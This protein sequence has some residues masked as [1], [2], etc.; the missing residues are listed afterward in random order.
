V[1]RSGVDL[2]VHRMR[3]AE[4]RDAHAAVA[5]DE[6]VRRL[7][8][9]VD[10][11]NG[12]R[13]GQTAPRLG[14]NPDDLLPRTPLLRE[15]PIERLSLDELHDDEN[16]I[17]VSPHV[18]HGDHVGVREPS[19]RA[20]FAEQARLQSIDARTQRVFGAHELQGNLAT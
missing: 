19:H 10:D 3:E 7:E 17:F 8:V 9:P 14:E 6:H 4:V 20:G 2:D 13:R 16:L 15:P 12:V 5:S 1:L 18:E 11:L